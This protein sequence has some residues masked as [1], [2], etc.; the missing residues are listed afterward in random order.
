D[1]IHPTR[2][3]IEPA[4]IDT[5][6]EAAETHS[7]LRTSDQSSTFH[8]RSWS[9]GACA[10]DRILPAN[11]TNPKAASHLIRLGIAGKADVRGR[12][13][14]ER[15]IKCGDRCCKSRRSRGAPADGGRPPAFHPRR[16][17]GT[18]SKYICGTRVVT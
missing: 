10:A 14:Q 18:A 17:C 12:L 5:G 15:N 13:R 2:T 9:R 16:D 4:E 11:T 3:E 8:V 6:L 7:G 1:D